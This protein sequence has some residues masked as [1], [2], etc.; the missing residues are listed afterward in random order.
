MITRAVS[1]KGILLPLA[2]IAI[3]SSCTKEKSGA[4][5]STV[6]NANSTIAVE[7]SS[8]SSSSGDSIYILCGSG[9]RTSISESELSASISAYLTTNYAGY[10]F[11]KAFAK[12]DNTGTVT[13]YVVVIFY[14]D[15]PVGIQFDA[16]GNFVRVL[17]QRERGD[18]NG[19][20][21][22]DG[23][24]FRHRDGRCRDTI[25]LNLVP[26]SILTYM[27]T[28]YPTDTLVRA[29]VNVHDSNYV[30]ISQ[31]NGLYA[32]VFTSTGVFIK[33]VAL[34]TP[35]GHCQPIAQSALP[36]TVQAYLTATYPNYVFEK[37]FAGYRNGT[38]QGYVVVIN[39][40]NTKYAVKFDATGNFVAVRV[41]W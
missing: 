13:G 38:I 19:P 39:A 40:N 25:A 26:V 37:A 11:K 34:P 31:N 12:K 20:G 5:D 8:R 36:L 10:T 24:R 17:E 28:N 29:S 2:F 30:I 14:N 21:F 15:K 6:I 16:S 22:H 33:R 27:L 18:L 1:V 7:A 35:A 4:D 23:G 9:T 41:I 32:S 3:Y